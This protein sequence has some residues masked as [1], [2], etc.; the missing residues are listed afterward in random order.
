MNFFQPSRLNNIEPFHVMEVMK[1]AEE[2]EKSGKSLIHMGVGEP[3]FTAPDQVIKS[4]QKKMNSRKTGYSAAT[5]I[6]ELRK[7]ISNYY[8]EYF[9]LDVSF[10][11]III[12]PG[13]SGAMLLACAALVDRDSEVLMPDPSYP[14]NRHFVS[15]FEGI[16]R[17]IPVGPTTK[18]QLSLD[19]LNQEWK[20]LTSGVMLASPSNPTGTNINSSELNKII[21]FAI[22]REGFVL[23]DEI[24]QGL[25]YDEK[26]FSSLTLSDEVIVVNS[27]SKYFNMTGWRLGWMVVPEKMFSTIEKLAQNFFICPSVISQTAALSCFEFDCIKIFEKRKNIFK[28]RRDFLVP[29]LEKIGFKIPVL[30]DGAFYIYADCSLFSDNSEIFCNTIL[31]KTGVVTVPGLDF[32]TNNSKKYIRFSYATSIENLKEAVFR[33]KKFLI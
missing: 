17:M 20:D 30:P 11:R 24:Y 19:N 33:L 4:A 1:R 14:C 6:V 9:D 8:L 7:A 5:G 31:E 18:F 32:G 2:M 3:D 16:S 12:T 28:E 26:P 23:V 29:E 21:Q 10:N 13:A 15:A 25:T 22:K 27:F